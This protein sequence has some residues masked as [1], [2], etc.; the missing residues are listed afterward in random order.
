MT[1]IILR[2]KC[3]SCHQKGKKGLKGWSGAYRLNGTISGLNKYI[4]I[5]CGS[6]FVPEYHNNGRG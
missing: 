6:G 4:C 3:I 1:N 5:N 2:K